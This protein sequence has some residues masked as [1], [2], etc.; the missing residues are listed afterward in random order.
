MT[1]IIT[2]IYEQGRLRP[3]Q[4]LNL[5]E[6]ET[7]QLQLLTPTNDNKS[8]LTALINAGLIRAEAPTEVPPKVPAERRQAAA[9]AFGAAGPVSELIIQDRG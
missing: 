3:L 5:R 7:V 8:A 6:N 1:Q 9:D 2:A 4:K